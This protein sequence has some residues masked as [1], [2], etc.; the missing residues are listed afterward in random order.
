VDHASQARSLTELLGLT[1]P[2]VAISFVA[3]APAGVPHAAQPA[4][5]S[6]SYWARAAAGEVF[7]TD[8]ADHQGCPIGAHTHGVPLQPATAAELG[9][10]VQIMVKLEYLGEAEVPRIPTRKGPFGAAVYAPLAQA[11]LPPDVVVVRGEA[12]RVMVLAEAARAAGVDAEGQ[13]MGRP[14]CAMLPQAM[15]SARGQLSLGCIG[16]RVYTE[17]GDGEI[18][19]A[20][21]GSKL[22]AVL[23]RLA[24]V[25]AANRE[26]EQLHRERKARPRA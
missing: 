2:P 14:A 15:D 3:Q 21:P 5:A 23:E 11:P 19:Y 6:C 1:S 16:N 9:Q 24:V 12:R 4:P 7:A 18:Y 25:A 26:L 20:L 22:Q 8:A 17:L 13:V 10:L